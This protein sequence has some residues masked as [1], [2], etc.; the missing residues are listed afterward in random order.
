[1][2]SIFLDAGIFRA[3]Y[4]VYKSGWHQYSCFCSQWNHPPLP[5]SEHT[6]CQ[7]AALMAQSVGWGT[8]RSY[9]SAL[10]YFQ[11]R[12]G[13]PDPSLA[14]FPRLTYVLKGIHR[15]KPDGSC[16][17]RL[18]ITLPI[19]LQL[20]KIWSTPPVTYDNTML[21]AA[22]C[23]GFFGFLQAGE[24]TLSGSVSAGSHLSP[25]DNHNPR[26][27][28]IHLR[29][30]KTDILWSWLQSLFS[31]HKHCSMPSG[32]SVEIGLCITSSLH[33]T[34]FIIPVFV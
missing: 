26:L 23:L 29:Y 34:S 27:L 12:A 30:S 22:C 2:D 16:R 10:R 32:S 33:I 31:S 19:L 5:L 8:I 17:H 15:T 18:P 1:V 6:L 4:A 13:L 24:F 21:W 7:F 11:I 14:A 9:L 3:T 25:S 28:T 20:H